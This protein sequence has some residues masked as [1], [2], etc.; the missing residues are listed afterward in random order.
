VPK[1]AAGSITKCRDAAAQGKEKREQAQ[2]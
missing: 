1:Q 2:K